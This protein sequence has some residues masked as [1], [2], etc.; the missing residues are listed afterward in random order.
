[1]VKRPRALAQSRAAVLGTLFVLGWAL[2]VGLPGIDLTGIR[3]HHQ[4]QSL[5]VAEM[6]A[7]VAA[8]LFIRASPLG[9]PK[10]RSSLGTFAAAAFLLA[11]VA[12][13][14]FDVELLEIK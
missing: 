14:L 7:I 6:L 3:F 9:L 10:L 1:M 12:A 2:R 13:V 5:R 8:L 4:V 11:G